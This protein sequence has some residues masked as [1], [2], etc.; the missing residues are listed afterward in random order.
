M[1]AAK[2]V[3]D[4]AVFGKLSCAGL[5]PLSKDPKIRKV[6]KFIEARMAES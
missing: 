3:A 2:A 5:P 4:R 1:W 6:Q